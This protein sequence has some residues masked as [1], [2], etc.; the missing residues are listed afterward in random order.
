VQLLA[1]RDEEAARTALWGAIAAASPGVTVS[2][3]FLTADQQWAI[4]VAL[5]ANLALSPYGPMFT[6]GDVGPLAPYV[7]SGAFL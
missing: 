4:Q 7:P 6:R 2:V 3:D 1:A 5:E